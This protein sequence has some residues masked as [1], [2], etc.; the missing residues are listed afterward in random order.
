MTHKT[1][2]DRLPFQNVISLLTKFAERQKNV[3]QKIKLI[4]LNVKV[5]TAGCLCL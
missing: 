5:M 3:K 1:G 2:L 4:S